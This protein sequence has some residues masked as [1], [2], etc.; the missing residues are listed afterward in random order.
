MGLTTGVRFRR[1]EDIHIFSIMSR[2]A[3]GFEEPSI[4]WVPAELPQG[5]K[6]QGREVDHSPPSS[7][8]AKNGGA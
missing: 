6:G 7:A 5:V 2:P 1:A 3:L 4:P 8:D